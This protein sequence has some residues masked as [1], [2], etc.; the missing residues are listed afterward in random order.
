[1]QAIQLVSS[2]ETEAATLRKDAL[3]NA[4]QSLRP[5]LEVRIRK[6]IE[7]DITERVRR[8]LEAKH[9]KEMDALRE[10]EQKW[11]DGYKNQKGK[12]ERLREANN[13]KSTGSM[14]S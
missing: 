5:K 7:K 11:K 2:T 14:V 3:K 13:A 10:S 8:E 4:E 12:L 1:M 6:E 9:K